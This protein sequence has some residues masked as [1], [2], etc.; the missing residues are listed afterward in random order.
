MLRNYFFINMCLVIFIGFLGYELYHVSAYTV[1]IPVMSEINDI[2]KDIIKTKDKQAAFN[3]ASFQVISQMDLFRPSRKPPVFK[4]EKKVK[5]IQKKNIPKLFG[6]IIF[7]DIKTAILEDPESKTTK[8]YKLNESVS[9][10]TVAE[11]LEDKVVL[12]SG[13]EKVEV[14]LRDEKGIKT[15]RKSSYKSK[16]RRKI[17]KSSRKPRSKPKPRRLPRSRSSKSTALTPSTHDGM[18][19]EI[20]RAINDIPPSPGKY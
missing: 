6:T 17:R 14:R 20:K 7:G 3:E 5:E 11:I 18:P 8:S 12:L 2:K 16:S 19:E 13:S 15:K 10:F 9:G 1:E 4:V